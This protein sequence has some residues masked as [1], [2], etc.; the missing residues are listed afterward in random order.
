M[1][2][3]IRSAEKRILISEIPN[4]IK[5]NDKSIEK[6]NLIKDILNFTLGFETK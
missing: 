2:P 5:Y 1:E 4:L 6:F 3:F